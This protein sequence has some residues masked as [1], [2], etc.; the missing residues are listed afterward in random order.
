MGKITGMESREELPEKVL[1]LYEAVARMVEEGADIANVKVSEITERAGIGKGTA[2]DYFDTKEEIIVY[3][4]IFYMEN[5][6]KELE[7]GIWEEKDFAGRVRLA[8]ERTNR[9]IAARTCALRF[10]NMLFDTTQMG[11]LLRR[12]LEKRSGGAC[13]PLL[14]A[15]AVIKKGIED[16]ELRTDIPSSY[17]TYILVTKFIAYMTYLMHPGEKECSNEEFCRYVYQG[18]LQEFG[19]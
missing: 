15:D 19:C 12:T 5:N 13:E 6:M 3:A 14:F 9:Q 10:V 4:V 17:M 1:L 18:I 11:Q 7:A 8:L 2:Y 16:G